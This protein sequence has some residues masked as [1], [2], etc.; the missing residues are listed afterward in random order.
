MTPVVRPAT[1]AD[2]L[3]ILEVRKASWRATYGAYLPDQVWDEMDPAAG[4]V[5]W[6]P[7][8]ADGRHRGLVAEVDGAVR[9]YALYGPCRDEDLPDAGEVM[10]I[11]AHP[12]NWSTGMGRALLPAAVAALD[13][14]PVVLWVLEVN[15]RARRFYERAG[16]RPDGGRQP[17]DMPGGV[18]LPEI[19]YRLD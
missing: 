13:R 17:A 8:L 16:F 3:A 4:A 9:A 19:R 2:A 18:V 7:F 14:R 10:A 12:D 5:R 6:A 1:A 15:A 11:Y